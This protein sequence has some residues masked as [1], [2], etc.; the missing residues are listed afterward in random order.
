MDNRCVLLVLS[1][2]AAAIPAASAAPAAQLNITNIGS[3]NL[4][5]HLSLSGPTGAVSSL[6]FSTATDL[7]T[8][9]SGTNGTPI[10]LN[11]SNRA[12]LGSNDI[13]ATLSQPRGVS[14]LVTQVN[15]IIAPDTPS[16][17]YDAIITAN[18]PGANST[19]I[20]VHLAVYNPT[21]AT[22]RHAGANTTSQQVVGV[23][24]VPPS[25]AL[26][27]NLARANQP[28]I[29]YTTTTTIPQAPKPSTPTAALY[30]AAAAAAAIAVVAYLLLSKRK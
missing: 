3:L 23:M 25:N 13:N 15:F 20:T 28:V 2:F 1:I 12:Y 29:S 14:P 22:F 24:H 30:T 5:L 7:K 16:G 10:S 26:Y 9:Y 19:G 21:N 17:V 4:S 8:T 18:A 6:D 27:A 11:L